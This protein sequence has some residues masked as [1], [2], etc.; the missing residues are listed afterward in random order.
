MVEV[1]TETGKVELLRMVTV[2]DAG[3]VLNPM[4]ARGQVHGGVAQAIGQ[5]LYEEFVYDDDGNPLTSSF[6]DYGFPSAAELPSFE[7]HLTQH[8]SPQNPLGVKGI[9]EAGANGGVP[10]VQNA[11]VDALAHLGVRHLDLPVTP[12][13]VWEALKD[14]LSPEPGV[15]VGEER[16]RR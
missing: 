11:V 4:L 9:A 7:C 13:R 5:A 8:P 3:V 14:H 15:S 10:A 1:D 2:D 16:K 12:Q 6:L